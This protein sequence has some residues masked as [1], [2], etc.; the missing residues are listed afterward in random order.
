VIS[1]SIIIC[2]VA[3]AHHRNGVAERAIQ[4]MS[5]IARAMLLDASVNRKNSIEPELWPMAV[6]YET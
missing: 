4:T 5:N 2:K 3:N 6:S 1:D